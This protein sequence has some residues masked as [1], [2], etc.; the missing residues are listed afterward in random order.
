MGNK[1]FNKKMFVIS[2]FIVSTLL[3]HYPNLK[4]AGN[5]DF[6]LEVS[7]NDLTVLTGENIST[8]IFINQ[9]SDSTDNVTLKG[10]WLNGQKPSDV[11]VNIS[12]KSAVPSFQ[13]TLKFITT[14]ESTT[15]SFVYNIT[16]ERDNKSHS[17]NLELCITDLS[18]SI[19]TNKENYEHYNMIHVSGNITTIDEYIF[20]DEITLEFKKAN[21]DWKRIIATSAINNSFDYYYNISFGDPPSGEDDE[22]EGIWKITAKIIDDNGRELSDNANVNVSIPTDTVIYTNTWK[23]PAEGTVYNRGETFTIS[24]NV[25][26]DENFIQNA[27]TRCI[28]PTLEIINLTEKEPGYYQNTY[29]IPYSSQSGKWY[30]SVDSIKNNSGTLNAGGSYTYIEINPVKLNLTLLAPDTNTSNELYPGD[31]INIKVDL[32]YPDETPVTDATVTASIPSETLIL[33]HRNQGIYLT[34]YTIKDKDVE[35]WFLNIS[36]TDKHGNYGSAVESITVKNK[37]EESSDEGKEKQGLPLTTIFGVLAAILISIFLLNFVQKRFSKQ[38]IEDI[39]T[40]IKEIKRL[41]NEAVEKYYKKG[42]INRPTYDN[43]RHEYSSRLDE[44]KKE[45]SKI[46]K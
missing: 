19:S 21:T 18:I 46:K 10:S 16:A 27:T 25:K 33:K 6:S 36:A 24:I 34:N 41:Q 9:T 13:S 32:K 40:E 12:T 14:E 4:A 1:L 39:Q 29:R 43:L 28:L 42:S 45:K 31:E 7:D 2:I 38:N 11:T 30:L 35:N 23:S 20:S 26:K 22:T 17:I 15:G 5:H 8:I 37:P 3:V 44:L